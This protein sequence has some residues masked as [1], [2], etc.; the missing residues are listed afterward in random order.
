MTS[1]LM[2]NSAIQPLLLRSPNSAH[3]HPLILTPEMVLTASPTTDSSHHRRCQ[4]S[5]R[6]SLVVRPR[7]PSRIAT[8]TLTARA[9]MT[10]RWM[11]MATTSTTKTR[12]TGLLHAA[13]SALVESAGTATSP[14]PLLPVAR[15]CAVSGAKPAAP[16]G[17][18]SIPRLAGARTRN[19]TS[20]RAPGA[21]PPSRA[22]QTWNATSLPSTAR[23]TPIST[24]A[25]SAR[26]NFLERMRCYA[27]R[28][29]AARNVRRKRRS[30]SGSDFGL[31]F[32]FARCLF[33]LLIASYL[34]GIPTGFAV[35]HYTCLV[36]HGLSRCRRV[37]S[38]RVHVLLLP[39]FVS[40]TS[41][42]KVT[43]SFM[44]SHIH[45]RLSQRN[46][47]SRRCHDQ[48]MI[49]QTHSLTMDTLY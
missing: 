28:T 6:A 5:T 47:W 9:T 46:L 1:S 34:L 13:G 35:C 49:S 8:S 20:A 2:L 33:S 7:A 19:A 18:L 42:P 16:A 43:R 22:S 4:L 45:F 44:T 10:M 3:L 25:R 32:S 11:Q 37:P 36:V 31:V 41:Y 39:L 15:A 30:R 27:T 26:S 48:L 40:L 14:T 12:T 29:I 17:A 24:D 38:F 23:R 21:H